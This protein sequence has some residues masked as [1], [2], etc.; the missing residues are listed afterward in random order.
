MSMNMSIQ[1][2]GSELVSRGGVARRPQSEVMHEQCKIAILLY[3]HSIAAVEFISKDLERRV[4]DQWVPS[5]AREAKDLRAIVSQLREALPVKSSVAPLVEAAKEYWANQ[6]SQSGLIVP[7]VP[8]VR[9]PKPVTGIEHAWMDWLNR[10]NQVKAGRWRNHWRT[11]T[12]SWKRG[13]RGGWNTNLCDYDRDPELRAKYPMEKGM[14]YPPQGF[15]DDARAWR[16][17][18]HDSQA[19]EIERA[20]AERARVIEEWFGESDR[21]VERFKEYCLAKGVKIW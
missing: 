11:T 14:N 17:A 8:Q 16:Q 5:Y 4:R 12:F 6:V 10:R 2:E 20:K 9:D 15:S 13:S 18:F 19:D 21:R 7:E 3:G 1:C